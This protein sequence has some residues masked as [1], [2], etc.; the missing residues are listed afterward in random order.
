MQVIDVQKVV[1]ADQGLARRHKIWL[2][3]VLCRELS[4]V[5]LAALAL[6][7]GERSCRGPRAGHLAHLL[8]GFFYVSGVRV[9]GK[10]KCGSYLRSSWYLTTS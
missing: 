8:V 5:V 10:Q 1:V 7:V 4:D 6:V 2:R 9:K 3:W